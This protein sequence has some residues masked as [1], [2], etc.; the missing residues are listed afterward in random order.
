MSVAGPFRGRAS[1]LFAARA[2]LLLVSLLW[3]LNYVAANF[4]LRAFSPWTFRALSFI[5]GAGALA[6][7]ARLT[8]A[9]LRVERTRD[10][11]HLVVS[12]LFACGGFG[13][14]SAIAILHTSTGRAAICAYTMPIWV[15][16]FARVVL[17]EALTPARLLALA[18]CAG[19][20]FVLL[21]PLVG[22]GAS[23]G[24]L[25]AIGSAISWA[26]GI[27]YLKWARVPAHPL[28]VALYQLLAGA[29]TSVLGVLLTGPGIATP[30]G[31]LP[32][33]GLLYAAIAGTAVAYLLW[34]WL[35]H[36][37]PAGTAGLGALLVPVFGVA[38]SV[39]ILGE[40]PSHADLAGLVMILAAAMVALRT[41]PSA[42]RNGTE[43]K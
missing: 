21:R 31:P 18:L 11:L 40:R 27:V 35:L 33:L 30:V 25:A 32:W 41:P 7:L 20:L 37:L 39:I 36:E 34:F 43:T 14:L 23:L 24:A 17:K 9:S 38:A 13:A 16:L 12:G 4:A 29:A 3:G 5:A 10:L 26:I 42:T 28:A 8:G 1:G 22:A 6:L 15:A 19:G 2:A